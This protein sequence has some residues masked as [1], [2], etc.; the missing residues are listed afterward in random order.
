MIVFLLVFSLLL[1]RGPAPQAAGI[2]GQLQTRDGAPASAVRVS[3]IQAP[4]PNVRPE[5]G[6][7][8]YEAPPPTRTALSDA[9]G[10]Y[11]L[12][13]LPPGRYYIVAAIA[14]Q[15]T[16]YPGTADRDRATIVTVERGSTLTA[17]FRLAIPL[18]G[19][20]AGR[21][22]P[23]PAPGAEEKAVLS[24][25][26]LEDVIETPI[27][28]DGSFEFGHMPHDTYL[29]NVAP[30]PPGLGSI[31]FQLRDDDLTTLQFMRPPTHVVSGRVVVDRGPLPVAWLAFSTPQTYEPVAIGADGTFSVRLQ[32]AHHRA[33]LAGMPVGYS[34]GSVRIG[35]TD[36]SDG[37][38]VANADVSGVVVNV[39][40]P[41]A[42][43]HVRGRV[44]TSTGASKLPPRVR[45]EG[46]IIGA[47]EASVG[48]NG[49]FDFPAVTPGHYTLSV[50]Q[51]SEF[52]PR[53][54]VVDWNDANVEVRATAK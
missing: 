48:P 22:T 4:P 31:A 36:A 15:G 45:L 49:V 12:A 23:P 46:P 32:S 51:T 11:R 1:Q 9:Q 54:L 26:K 24:G 34:I 25:V 47:L 19:R 10:R 42:L 53:S 18:G 33:E 2:T 44:I 3:A 17:D 7:Q 30:T 6:I 37:F 21:I 39:R 43:P 14:G 8:Y 35:S 41:R 5:E 40:A 27:G 13:N 20:V 38:D 50:P 29:L 28:A 52:A 16:Y